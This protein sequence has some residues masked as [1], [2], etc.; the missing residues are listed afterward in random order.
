MDTKRKT[1]TIRLSEEDIK[2]IL[3]IRMHYGIASDNQAIIYAIRFTAQHLERS[4]ETRAKA[5]DA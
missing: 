3:A 2:A 1:T 4:G 5:T